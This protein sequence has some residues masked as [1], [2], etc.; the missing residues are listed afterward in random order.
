MGTKVEIH[1]RFIGW[2]PP[3]GA[4]AGPQYYHA[5]GD[6]LLVLSSALG[7][8]VLH[9]AGSPSIYGQ[10]DAVAEIAHASI[11][12]P[13]ILDPAKE[14]YVRMKKRMTAIGDNAALDVDWGLANVIDATTIADM[15]DASLTKYALFHLDGNSAN[16]LARSSDASTTV[17]ATDTTIDNSLT[18][19]KVFEIH[20]TSSGVV[21]L[22]I[23]GVQVLTSTT[24]AIPT[25]SASTGALGV[26][27]NMEKTSDDTLGAWLLEELDIVGETV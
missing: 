25:S 18:V 12:L 13:P 11:Y 19:M 27:L 23:D 21:K 8:G 24:F 3:T 16:I 15:G 7:L 20:K 2:A 17:S 4:V 5:N 14:I 10:F 26:I 9:T 6:A 1:E 22:W